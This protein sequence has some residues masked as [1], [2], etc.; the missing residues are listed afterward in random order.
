LLSDGRLSGR[1]SSGG[2]SGSGSGRLSGVGSSPLLLL[3]PSGS[4]AVV[5]GWRREEGREIEESAK[6]NERRKRGRTS[7]SRETREFDE[8]RANEKE[9]KERTVGLS[10]VRVVRRHSSVV[11]RSGGSRLSLLTLS[12]S[13]RSVGRKG[14]GLSRSGLSRLGLLSSLVESRVGVVESR[15]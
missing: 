14:G 5:V 6:G 12:G 7:S 9:K 3:S 8:R 15:L 13:L 4:L 11:S 1:G 10:P 2:R